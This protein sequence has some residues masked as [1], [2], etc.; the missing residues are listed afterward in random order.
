MDKEILNRAIRAFARE[1]GIDA[2]DIKS[3]PVIPGYTSFYFRNKP[4]EPI[5]INAYRPLIP[6]D[7]ACASC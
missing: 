5:S 1:M 7:S 2:R 3:L 4:D 6:Q